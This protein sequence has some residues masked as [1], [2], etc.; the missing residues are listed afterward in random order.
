MA[1][2]VYPAIPHEHPAVNCTANFLLLGTGVN[3]NLDITF[4]AGWFFTQMGILKQ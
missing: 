3:R 4:I 2:P 1:P